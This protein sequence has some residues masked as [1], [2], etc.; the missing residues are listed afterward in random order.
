M[1]D[2]E[3]LT[4]GALVTLLLFLAPGYLLHVSPRFA[5]SIGGGMLGIAGAILLVLLLVYPL[6]KHVNWLNV[7]VTRRLPLRSLLAFHVYAGV[8]GPVLG[9]LHSGHNYQSPLGIALVLAMLIVVLSGFVGRYYLAY[10]AIGLRQQEGTLATLREAYNRIADTL[11]GREA[12]PSDLAGKVAGAR[13]SIPILPL[14]DTIAELEY[15][16]GARE[17]VRQV[18]GRWMVVHVTASIVMYFLLAL[19][20]WSGLYYGLRWLP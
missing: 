8:V 16:I 11:A 10:V 20:I 7:R 1:S 14:V 13:G 4:V 5:G 15:A 17:K 18:L 19:H 12:I 6:V 2:K 3:R 9:I